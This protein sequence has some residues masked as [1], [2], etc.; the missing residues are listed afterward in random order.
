MSEVIKRVD[1]SNRFNKLLKKSPLEIK[2]TFKDRYKLFMHDQFHPRLNNHLLKGK[3]SGYRSI[4]IT[5]DW[6]VIYSEYKDDKNNQIVI[7]ELIGT[8][9]QLY[10]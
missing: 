6:R 9:S 4:N 3:F 8:H 1:F 7:F 2:L 10:K 5:G